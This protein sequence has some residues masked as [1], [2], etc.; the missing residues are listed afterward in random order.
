MLS[1]AQWVWLLGVLVGPIWAQNAKFRGQ[2]VCLAG[3]V[4]LMPQQSKARE[5]SPFM[6]QQGCLRLQGLAWQRHVCI[7][8]QTAAEET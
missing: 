1:T 4:Q 8:L 6:I 3:H 2:T 5:S 7:Q